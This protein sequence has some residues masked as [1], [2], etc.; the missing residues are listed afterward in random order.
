MKLSLKFL[1]AGLVAFGVATSAIAQK[2]STSALQIT[3][4]S[5]RQYARSS[6]LTLTPTAQ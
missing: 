6:S 3:G 1:A 2:P 5:P 4:S